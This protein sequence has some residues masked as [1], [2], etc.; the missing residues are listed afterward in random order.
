MQQL[1]RSVGQF[2]LGAAPV[3]QLWMTVRAGA[4]AASCGLVEGIKK[5]NVFG[6]AGFGGAGGTAKGLSA[7]DSEVELSVIGCVVGFDR[8]PL[9]FCRNDHPALSETQE[10]QS[11]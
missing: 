3:I 10:Y 7:L 9:F 8:Q 4:A 6:S 2:S 11:K 1:L 5:N